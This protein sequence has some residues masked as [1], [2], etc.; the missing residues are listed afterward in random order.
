MH[1][2]SMNSCAMDRHLNGDMQCCLQWCNATFEVI[3][4]SQNCQVRSNTVPFIFMD[5]N[6]FIMKPHTTKEQ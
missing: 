6:Q 2:K 5:K 4:Q 3:N 1:R